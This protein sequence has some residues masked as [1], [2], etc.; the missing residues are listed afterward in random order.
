MVRPNPRN[1]IP[2]SLQLPSSDFLHDIP[3]HRVEHV[4]QR[5]V[6]KARDLGVQLVDVVDGVALRQVEFGLHWSRARLGERGGEGGVQRTTIAASVL[7]Y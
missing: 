2:E 6:G 5:L 1:G 7:L 3:R 4:E